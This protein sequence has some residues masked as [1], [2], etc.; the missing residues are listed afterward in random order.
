MRISLAAALLCICVLIPLSLEAL[1]PTSTVTGGP[2]SSPAA[3][4][5]QQA[6]GVLSGGAPITDV[7]MTGAVTV[8]GVISASGTVK[9]VATASGQG[10]VTISL[11]SGTHTEIRTDS[12]GS[13]TLAETGEDGVMHAVHTQSILAPHPSCLLPAL[14]LNSALSSSD[15]AG[16]YVGLGSWNG[17]PAQHVAVWLQ[18]SNTLS[19]STADLQRFSQHDIYLDPSSLLPVAMTF[20]VHPYDS[21]NP[22]AP[23]TPYRGNVVDRLE[24]VTFSDYRQVEGRPVAFHVRTSVTLPS[25]ALVSD[26]QFSSV[27]FNTGATVAAN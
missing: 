22:D 11:P 15:Y 7:T 6:F 4:I 19:L 5:L 18:N 21:A 2:Q 20:T 26:F 13:Q 23:L 8:S 27:G 17:T 24:Q 25:G 16:T 1:P 14:I 3:P 12:S 10:Q 9:F